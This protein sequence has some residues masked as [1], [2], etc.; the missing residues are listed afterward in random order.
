MV[1]DAPILIGVTGASGAP[2]ALRVIR[3]LHEAGRPPVVIISEG[4][5][6]VLRE[7]SGLPLDALRPWALEIANDKDL[8][9]AYASGSRP[10]QAM[11]VV[12]CS[13]HTAAKIAL[14]LADTLVT[15]A[16][17]VHLKERR[18]LL[19]VVRET[20]LSPI[21]LGHLT[22]LAEL[23]V[24]ILP[25]EPAYYLHPKTIE[26]V[27]DYLAGKVLDHLHVPH[28]LYRG[29]KVGVPG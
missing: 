20:P 10:T 7:E 14:G 13:S 24:V 5:E 17:H 21:L 8:A 28:Q 6:A 18:P 9:H 4:A 11:A 2:I 1:E 26:D 25:P 22:R 29:W 19:L 15:R 16:A 27:T 3:A 12:P 23:G